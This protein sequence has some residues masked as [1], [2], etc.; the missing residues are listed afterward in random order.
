MPPLSSKLNI[1]QQTSRAR[2]SWLA[3]ARSSSNKP[4]SQPGA[5]RRRIAP[6][7]SMSSAL[8]HSRQ[9][10][11]FRNGTYEAWPGGHLRRSQLVP[12]RFIEFKQYLEPNHI[13]SKTYLEFLD[14]KRKIF[15]R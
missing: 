3:H 15:R 5:R 14:A 12:S 6:G 9:L 10:A 4:S 1:R 8:G 7:L 13:R 11:V 2:L